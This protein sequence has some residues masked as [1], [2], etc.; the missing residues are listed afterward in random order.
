MLYKKNKEIY[1]ELVTNICGRSLEI[2]KEMQ[3][4][5]RKKKVKNL[6][7]YDGRDVIAVGF[8]GRQK[9]KA[10][11]FVSSTFSGPKVHDIKRREEKKKE[12]K[13]LNKMNR[14]AGKNK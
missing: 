1:G 7:V 14:L 9:H 12:K 4:A 8:K 6:K 13:R 11:E 5:L 3:K 2:N 10:G